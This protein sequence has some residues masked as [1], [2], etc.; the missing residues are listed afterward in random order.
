MPI[1]WF[2]LKLRVQWICKV[3]RER[4]R[5]AEPELGWVRPPSLNQFHFYFYN[6][7][8][9][10]LLFAIIIQLHMNDLAILAR[11]WFLLRVFVIISFFARWPF[12]SIGRWFER[13]AFLDGTCI[14]SGGGRI[15]GHTQ[16]FF[17]CWCSPFIII[18]VTFNDFVEFIKY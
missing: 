15:F 3:Q 12:W 18:I 17:F 11:R 13:K 5:E 6:F 4:A 7:Q 2:E 9:V 16:I 14:S 8:I 10:H 1:A